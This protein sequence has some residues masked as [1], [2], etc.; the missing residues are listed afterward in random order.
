MEFKEILTDNGSKFA[1][2]KQTKNKDNY[3]FERLLQE[4]NIKHRYNKPY[5]PQTNGK[6]ERIWRIIDE[7]LLND[8]VFKNKEHLKEEIMKYNHYNEYRQYIYLNNKTPKEYLL[9]EYKR[10]NKEIILNK[11]I[12]IN[13]KE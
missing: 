7:E 8:M 9:E 1:N 6:M 11:N 3:P 13:I 12:N 5:Y 4:L 10:L 2:G